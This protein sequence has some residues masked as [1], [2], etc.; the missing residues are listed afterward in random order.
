MHNKGN[1]WEWWAPG[2]ATMLSFKTSR[3]DA[4]MEDYHCGCSILVT[5]ALSR[6]DQLLTFLARLDHMGGPG[7]RPGGGMPPG[8]ASSGPSLLATPAL[9]AASA[10]TRQCF[11]LFAQ[12]VAGLANHFSRAQVLDTV[13][14]GRVLRP[15]LSSTALAVTCGAR[16]REG[17][18]AQRGLQQG[19]AIPGTSTARALGA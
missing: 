5:T 17:P 1:Q 14:E 12:G 8:L 13:R 9:A 4:C 15:S 3:R 19:W 16:Q 18:R 6:G 10:A 7:T 2:M 11:S